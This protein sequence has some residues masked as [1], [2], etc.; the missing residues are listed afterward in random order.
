VP[1]EPLIHFWCPDPQCAGID[2]WDP[3]AEPQRFASGV[4]HSLLELY[5][6]L[7]DDGTVA[8]EV[9]EAASRAPRLVVVAAGAIWRDRAAADAALQAIGRANDRYVLIR[10]DTPLWWHLPITPVVELMPNRSGMLKPHQRWLPPLPQRGLVPR[11][12][13]RIERIRRVAL[14]C[15]PDQLPAEARDPELVA[16][17]RG[18]GVELWIDAPRHTDGSDQRW[19]DFS[20]VDAALCVRPAGPPRDLSRKP[21][22]KLVNSWAAGCVPIAARE[23]A[24]LELATHGADAYFLESVDDLPDAVRTL[25]SSPE[26][27]G[28]IVDGVEERR[29][30]HEP[31][32]V[33]ALWRDMLVAACE[34]PC[35]RSGTRRAA[36]ALWRLRAFHRGARLRNRARWIKEALVQ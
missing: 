34:G 18:E 11:G 17:L 5:A 2:A 31:R 24:Y 14:K 35:E 26:L 20:S 16:A 28:A 1:D 30:E 15:N 12:G 19:H 3:D 13:A 21:A 33:L 6:R 27:L 7:R 23:P 29:R 25:N 10:G 36:V 8:V 9:G 4:G 32:R 22:T